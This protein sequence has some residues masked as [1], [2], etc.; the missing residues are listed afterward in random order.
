MER[1]LDALIADMYARNPW[2]RSSFLAGPSN[3]YL[4]AWQPSRGYLPGTQQ[5]H[6]L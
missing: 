2:S 5:Q 4:P 1:R 3:V 6:A